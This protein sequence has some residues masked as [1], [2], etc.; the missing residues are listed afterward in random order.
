[1][2]QAYFKNEISDGTYIPRFHSG[3]ANSEKVSKWPIVA[4]LISALGCMGCSTACHL[5]F[6]KNDKLYRIVC[7]LDYWGITMLILGTCYPFVSYRYSCGYLVIYRYIFIIILTILM[8][9]CMIVTMFPTFLSP[10]PKAILFMSFG[11]FCLIP[12]IMLYILY[13]PAYGMHPGLDPFTW[14]SLFYLIGLTFYV[15]KFPE[16]K[17]K[18]GRFDIYF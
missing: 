14:S 4:Y 2:E 15:T 10:K 11:A 13:D 16:C 8:V 17:S 3:F 6:C 12:T 9:T 5:C 1:M 18:T 7:T